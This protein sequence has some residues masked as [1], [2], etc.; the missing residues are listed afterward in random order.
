MKKVWRGQPALARRRFEILGVF[1]TVVLVM[2]ASASGVALADPVQEVAAVCDPIDQSDCLLP[3][4][5]NYFSAAD[6]STTTGIRLNVSP[7]ATPRN[8][9][10]TP[11][12]PTD[13][14][15]LDG[16]SP[17][18]QIVTH[19][20]G[21]D[22]PQ[23]FKNTN[24]PTNINIGRS[25]K[26]TSP[27][28]VLDATTGKL[29]PA[30]SELDRSR[31]L[32][33][34]PPPPERTA[35][36]IHPAKNFAEGHRYIVALRNMRN[37]GGTVIPAQPVFAAF[38]AGEGQPASRQS[39]YDTDIF[40]QL[41]A[42]SINVSSLYLA[43][44]FTVASQDSLSEPILSMRTDALAKLGDTTPGDGVVNGSA[45]Q[46][47][48]NTTPCTVTIGVP[49]ANCTGASSDPRVLVHVDGYVAVPC[50]LNAPGCP[51]GS[52]FQ[53]LTPS[54]VTPTPI[55][56]NV[57]DAH[58]ECNIPIGAARG[59]TFRVAM[60]GHGLFGSADEI[61]S[62]KYYGLGQYGV[63]SCAM[64]EIGMAEEDIPNALASLADLSDFPTIP[65]RLQ[66]G[67]IDFLYLGRD[68]LNPTGFCANAS[69]Q[70]NGK[71]VIDTSHLFYD[72]GSQGAI[73][74]GALTAMDP[75]FTRS[76]LDVA[77]MNY[78]M[79][80]TRSS[81]FTTFAEVLYRT[82]PDPLDREL[83][84]SF[85]QNV[86]DH[87]EADGYAEHMTTNPLP[88]TPRHSVLM[89]VAFGDHQVTNWA[90]E[91][92]ARTI[93]ARIREP[94]LDPA[95]PQLP[96]QG[97]GGHGGGRPWPAPALP[98]RWGYCV[99]RIPSRNTSA[100][101]RQQCKHR[102]RGSPRS[103]LGPIARRRGH[104]RPVAQ[105]ERRAA[106]GLRHRTVPHGGLDWTVRADSVVAMFAM[107]GRC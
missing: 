39:H 34:N 55:P 66:Q 56:G 105:G 45:P 28:I 79:L 12:D 31:D 68:V 40:P 92:E 95:H 67:M 38:L 89:T 9:A 99:Q 91:V 48:I 104:N 20:A 106:G 8:A 86:W 87:G 74:G 71:C 2:S 90:S 83:L 25:L 64:D 60:V 18:S 75:D 37:S 54:D 107:F 6:A 35:L 42:A 98:Q 103:G 101:T 30:W 76:E 10:G 80:L 96:V 16:F 70:V 17:G 15:R 72:G 36:L 11:L 47:V 65:D 63:M 53:Y 100:T 61:N 23:A 84:Y 59:E 3:W 58:F 24:P 50:Y 21:M 27:V 22:N 51:S 52:R 73:F 97:T 49:P 82:Y 19:V 69:F 78:S 46:F 5:N 1:F 94:V 32:D 13:W 44:D 4:P 88:D 7:L 81:D 41:R 85:I 33:G 57:Y 14:N 102:R 93:G 43:W 26:K 29:W 77:G 62:D